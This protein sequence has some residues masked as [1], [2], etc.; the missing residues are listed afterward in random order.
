MG[1]VVFLVSLFSSI[2]L[3]YLLRKRYL[4]YRY[5]HRKKKSSEWLV[6]DII[7]TLYPLNVKETGETYNRGI[8]VAWNTEIVILKRAEHPNSHWEINFSWVKENCSLS[9]RKRNDEMM[10]IMPESEQNKVLNFLTTLGEEPQ[11]SMKINY[12]GKLISQLNETE[13]NALINIAIE[14]KNNVVLNAL[15]VRLKEL[16]N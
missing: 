3:I 4:I 15:R 8:L 16:G 9:N 11:Q 1:W 5:N 10:R 2:F 6:G 14:E 7:E 13:C 12:R